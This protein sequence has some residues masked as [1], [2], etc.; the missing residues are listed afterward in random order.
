[1]ALE[2]IE[3][4]RVVTRLK[5]TELDFRRQV[6]GLAEMLGWDHVGFRAAQTVHGWRTPVTGTLGK[7]WPDLTLVRVRDR[8]LIFAE[9]KSA[10]GRTSPDQ[11]RV[12]DVLRCLEYDAA[13]APRIEVFVWHDTDLN[14]IVEVLR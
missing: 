9:L 4:R 6:I 13:P 14:A 11:D 10:K 12:L 8:R 5:I 3:V 1:V 7:G 2:R